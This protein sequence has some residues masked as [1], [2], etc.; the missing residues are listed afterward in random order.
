MQDRLGAVAKAP[1]V[2]GSVHGAV[3]SPAETG[4]E[5]A[6]GR[7]AAQPQLS[8]RAPRPLLSARPCSTPALHWDSSG[9]T[10]LPPRLPGC[11]SQEPLHTCVHACSPTSLMGTRG[12]STGS[13]PPCRE[14]ECTACAKDA[15]PCTKE[16]MWKTAA[17][18]LSSAQCRDG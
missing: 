10:L 1:P 12:H 5:Q 7:A 14:E 9:G 6:L 8:H 13:Q 16:I 3:W 15:I 2:K 4:G 17:D 18:G 11:H